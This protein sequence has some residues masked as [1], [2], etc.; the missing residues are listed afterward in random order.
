[1]DLLREMGRLSDRE[2]VRRLRVGWRGVLSNWRRRGE[3]PQELK[4]VLREYRELYREVRRRFPVARSAALRLPELRQRAFR[5]SPCRAREQIRQGLERVA[6][7]PGGI[8]VRSL[9]A[10]AAPGLSP[11][12][13]LVRVVRR[14]GR[15]LERD[16]GQG[17]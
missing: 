15:E 7:K 8:G 17:R 5:A 4:P 6:R 3:L 13:T 14:L 10:R 9:L 1:M 16:G 12:L 11:A 2:V